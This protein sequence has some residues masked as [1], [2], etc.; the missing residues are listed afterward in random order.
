MLG[1]VAQCVRQAI[2]STRRVSK[3]KACEPGV[4]HVHEFTRP[5]Y[6]NN[7]KT[8]IFARPRRGSFVAGNPFSPYL[9]PFSASTLS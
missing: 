6:K 1:T 7:K 2:R 8:P 4:D 9:E 3:A 5:V